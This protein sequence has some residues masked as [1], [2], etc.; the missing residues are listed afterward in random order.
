MLLT[1]CK[2]CGKFLPEG[3]HLWPVLIDEGSGIVTPMN[4][5]QTCYDTIG[6]DDSKLLLESA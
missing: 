4:V 1:I 2:K 6:N 5:C 3:E